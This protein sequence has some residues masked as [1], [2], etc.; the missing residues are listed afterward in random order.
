MKHNELHKKVPSSATEEIEPSR[1]PPPPPSYAADPPD[2]TAGFSR[3]NL[4]QRQSAKPIRDQCIAHLKLL[5]CFHELRETVATTDGLY[6][7]WDDFVPSNLTER[8]QAALLTKIRE[9]R[10]SIYVAQA[11]KRFELWWTHC[12]EPKS[13]M[14]KSSDKETSPDTWKRNISM[15]IEKTNLPPI[16]VLMVWHTFMLNPRDY[17]GDC[18]RYG[19][20]GL[21]ANGFPWDAVNACIDNDS[22]EYETR[23]EAHEFFKSRTGKP[24]DA[25]K[26]PSKVKIKCLICREPIAC[27]WTTCDHSLLWTGSLPGEGGLGFAEKGFSK[28]CPSCHFLVNHE[29]LKGRNFYIDVLRLKQNDTPMPGTLLDHNGM[30][31]QSHSLS[32]YE[33]F[34]NRLLNPDLLGN[35]IIM[36]VNP[37][38]QKQGEL[39]DL[40]VIRTHI[41]NGLKDRTIVRRATGSP[42]RSRLKRPERIAIRR[43]MSC[44][45]D[46]HSM[47]SIDLVGAVIRQGVFIEKMHAIDWLHSPSI[48]ATMDRL[49]IKYSRFFDIMG[50][51]SDRVSVPTLDVDLAWHTHQLC[52]KSYYAYATAKTGTFIDRDN[53][54]DE[55]RLPDAFE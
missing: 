25:F 41:E 37:K 47:F 23:K 55:N 12:A 45:W 9:K 44:Y 39:G 5:E 30:F 4:A 36:G 28:A 54:I 50:K 6:G 35:W 15:I 27:P 16:D 31:G 1:P 18:I 52:C 3:L 53:K 40:E 48:G 46:N 10:W 22:F 49:L 19:K 2:I 24:Y 29:K 17:L 34:P 14:M 43:M 26:M 11:A 8:D 38:V 20:R 42:S 32:Q 13:T 51:H 21:W 7:I 33:R